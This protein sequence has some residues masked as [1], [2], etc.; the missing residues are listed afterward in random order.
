MVL[1]PEEKQ[2]INPGLVAVFSFIF[3]GL[4]QIYNGQILKGLCIM[5]FSAVGMIFV[6]IGFVQIG[7][8]MMS[9]LFGRS[10]LVF[11]SILLIVGFLLITALSIYNIYDAYNTAQ[12]KLEN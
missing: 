3:S 6:I 5:A 11:G 1:T 4:G 8:C 12:Q 9:D 7:F 2:K 10:E